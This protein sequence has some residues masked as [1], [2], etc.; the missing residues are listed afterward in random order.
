MAATATFSPCAI[1]NVSIESTSQYR[2]TNPPI[3]F[4]IAQIAVYS[5]SAGNT[6]TIR[7]EDQYGTNIIATE[8]VDAGWTWLA[9]NELYASIGTRENLLVQ[10]DSTDVSKV[11]FYTTSFNPQNWAINI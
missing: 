2:I 4:R 11:I 6:I 7:S 10:A 9:I 1:L 8:T 5:S 3:A